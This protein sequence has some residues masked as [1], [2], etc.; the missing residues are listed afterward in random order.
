MRRLL[1]IC[2]MAVTLSAGLAACGEGDTTTVEDTQDSSLQLERV[3]GG[4]GGCLSASEVNQQVNEVASGFETSADEV[5]AK[6]D[7]IQGIRERA[8]N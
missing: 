1:A 8:C 5:Q 6:Q 2:F 4:E 3:D 7:E